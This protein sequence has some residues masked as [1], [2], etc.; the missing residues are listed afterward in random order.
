MW[1]CGLVLVQ[2]RVD[3]WWHGFGKSLQI[4][5]GVERFGKRRCECGGEVF[6]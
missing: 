6:L 5:S 4:M 3:V 1:W 2:R